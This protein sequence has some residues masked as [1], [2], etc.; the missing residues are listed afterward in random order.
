MGTFLYS[1]GQLCYT[2]VNDACGSMRK[3]KTGGVCKW[4]S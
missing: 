1:Q 2:D 4:I 3:W